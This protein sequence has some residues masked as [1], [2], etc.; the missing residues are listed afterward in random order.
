MASHTEDK[1]AR[2]VYFLSEHFSCIQDRMMELKVLLNFN[3][4]IEGPLSSATATWTAA[5][6]L[7]FLFY[8]KMGIKA[9]QRW[10]LTRLY[11]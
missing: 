1:Q 2:H 9:K 10:F 11:L 7:Y 6:T 8:I 5:S 4:Y 3:S